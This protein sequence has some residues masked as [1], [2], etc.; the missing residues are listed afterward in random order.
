MKPKTR[1]GLLGMVLLL[2]ASCGMVGDSGKVGKSGDELTTVNLQANL[3]GGTESKAS[4][5]PLA[6][7]TA[8]GSVVLEARTPD[9]ADPIVYTETQNVTAGQTDVTFSFTLPS[10]TTA[11]FIVRAYSGADGTGTLVYEGTTSGVVLDP[12][13]SIPV[14][15]TLDLVGTVPPTVTT[16]PAASV[17]STGA[18]L[19]GLVN[20]N[21]FETVAYFEWRELPGGA[22]TGTPIQP[23]GAGNA[24]VAVIQ[25]INGLT[26]GTD[27]EFRAVGSNSGN[28]VYGS[29]LQF[30]TPV[31]DVG[32]TI[33]FPTLT[34]PTV[35]TEA[36][37]GITTADAQL[38]ATV[39]P[40]GTDTYAYFDW[41]T[42]T[43]YG[44]STALQLMGNGTADTTPFDTLT[45]LTEATT[46][47]YRAVAYNAGGITYGADQAVTP[48]S[49]FTIAAVSGGSNHFMALREDGT[50]WTWGENAYG[51]LGDGTFANS[52]SPVQVIDP[53]DPTGYLAN[54]IFIES[55][56]DYAMAVK[57]DGT[58]WGWGYN[59]R[60]NLGD[61]TT[62]GQPTPV[63][64]IDTADPTGFLTDV[65]SVTADLDHTLALKSDGTVW[66]WGRNTHG[67]LG[68][69]SSDTC[70]G[71]SCSKTAIQVAGLSNIND[72][73][74][75]I[76]YSH[77]L[78]S[79]GTVWAW[80]GNP[81]GFL[82]TPSTETCGTTPCSTTP[83]QV[84]DS[85]DPT[86]FLTG[87]IKIS[88]GAGHTIVE[89]SDGTFW[90]WG[91]DW[92]GQLSV[93]TTETCSAGSCSTVP[94][95]LE[96]PG[97]PSGY[98]ADLRSFD[99]GGGH[100]VA[101]K[102]DGTVLAW[103]WND[104]GQLGATTSELCDGVYGCSSFPI[105][106]EDPTDPSGFLT[107]VESIVS[108]DLSS[109]ALKS[110]GTVWTWGNGSPNPAMVTGLNLN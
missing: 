17:T 79:D 66:A 10:G 97:D 18:T 8:V 110:D 52:S 93:T 25:V 33:T 75:G 109:I 98:L 50:V 11:C 84:E 60:G 59:Q 9:C 104:D 14:T 102:N 55:G 43:T 15:V 96:D 86:G 42:D 74:I 29:F 45:G 103:G 22:L 39:N 6:L 73:E 100:S 21:G 40:E 101:Q 37:S 41:G 35:T 85:G 48:A 90:G 27:Y 5:A 72:V 7:P 95:R 64:V 92:F 105:R 58:L 44:N 88:N 4:R 61:G 19:G 54:V 23:I 20:P 31:T 91:A 62:T 49:V 68:V 69:A 107:D 81:N 46:Y 65:V 106:V 47:H 87:V 76:Y 1:I 63:Q 70:G 38:N 2:V 36:A 80:G 30:T 56:R 16:E 108:A 3:P 32:I 24:D 13:T 34:P 71:L 57:A 89:K 77:A 12:D 78:R 83:I 51:Q 67:Q 53:S 26:P 82:G 28:L 94:V 99:G